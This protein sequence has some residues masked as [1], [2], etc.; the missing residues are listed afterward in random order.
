MNSTLIAKYYRIARE[1]FAE[2]GINVEEAISTL[3]ATPISIPCWQSENVIG[4]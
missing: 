4:L 2:Y 3:E 1:Q